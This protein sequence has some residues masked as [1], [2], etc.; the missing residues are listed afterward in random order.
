MNISRSSEYALLS[1][2]HIARDT[3]A[4]ITSLEGIAI[5]QHLPVEPLS[6]TLQA[7]VRGKYLRNTKAGYRLA[8]PANKIA[9][10]EIIRLFDGVFALFEPASQNGYK[11]SPVALEEKLCNLF[12]QIQDL[13]I[14]RLEN[15]TL[16][17]LV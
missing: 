17:D 12:D 5:S 13:V 14:N 2:I 6:E 9:V 11:P 7:L 3:G 16:A 15:T 10:A 4:G 8:K 1:L